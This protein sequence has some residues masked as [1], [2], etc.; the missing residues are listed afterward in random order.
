MVLVPG[1]NGMWKSGRLFSNRFRC[2][3]NRLESCVGCT[4]GPSQLSC[5]DRVAGH[6]IASPIPFD[7]DPC[8]KKGCRCAELMMGH[9]ITSCSAS[10]KPQSTSVLICCCQHRYLFR[11]LHLHPHAYIICV[12]RTCLT[13]RKPVRLHCTTSFCCACF[14]PPDHVRIRR[15]TK[16]CGD[17][18][19]VMMY[20]YIYIYIYM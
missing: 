1:M 15:R 10:H 2:R 8:I 3:I 13:H 5:A 19:Q 17:A 4:K 18:S 11:Y 7:V 20:S 6:T 12:F 16:R 14:F 9:L